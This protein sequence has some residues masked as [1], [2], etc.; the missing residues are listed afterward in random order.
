MGLD[1]VVH[2][3]QP[4][5]LLQSLRHIGVLVSNICLINRL[6][7]QAW[8]KQNTSSAKQ[9]CIGSCAKWNVSS[10]LEEDWNAASAAC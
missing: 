9:L 5:Q 10:S 4:M 6:S 3:V 1:I 8:C 2:N 7:W